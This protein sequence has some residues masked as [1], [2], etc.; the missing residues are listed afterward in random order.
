MS[1][2]TWRTTRDKQDYPPGLHDLIN[3]A[4]ILLHNGAEYAGIFVHDQ[5]RCW[6]GWRDERGETRSQIFANPDEALRSAEALMAQGLI[7]PRR[8]SRF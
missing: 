4:H 6:L 2:Y 1:L 5:A 8:R 7:L 3:E